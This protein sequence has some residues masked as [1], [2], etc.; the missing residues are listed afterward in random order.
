MLDIF[1]EAERTVGI[2]AEQ[3]GFHQMVGHRGG[4]GFAAAQGLEDLS[5]NLG[6]RI[7][8]ES[9]HSVILLVS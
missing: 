5:T 9:G 1:I 2:V 7:G 4:V 6:E 8:G 3:T